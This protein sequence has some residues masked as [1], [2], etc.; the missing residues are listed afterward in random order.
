MRL[1]CDSNF[2][3]RD[4][5]F[6]PTRFYRLQGGGF[7]LVRSSDRQG[8]ENDA[9]AIAAGS[10]TPYETIADAADERDFVRRWTV[11]CGLGWPH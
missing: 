1:L 11:E 3:E 5:S 8:F 10:Y 9:A 6:S 2:G 4:I 7:A